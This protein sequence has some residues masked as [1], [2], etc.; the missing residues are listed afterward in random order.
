MEDGVA[1]RPVIR[2]RAPATSANL[3]PGFDCLA[4]ALDLENLI[5]V[6]PLAAGPL[7]IEVQGEGAEVLARDRSNLVVE[8]M[9]RLAAT[10]GRTLPP[11]ALRLCNAI[12]LG[13]GLGS[14]AAAIAGGLVVA[15]ALL[16][17]PTDLEILLPVALS[18]EEHPDNIAAALCGGFTVGVLDGER[19]IVY[20][21][22]PPQGLRAVLLVPD[23]FASTNESRAVL[24]TT[25]PRADAVYNS[26]RC[27]LLALALAEGRYDLLRVAMQDRLHQPQRG[28]GSFPYLGAAIAAALAA[29]AHGAA[30]SGAGSSVV[31]LATEN[32]EAIAAA[33]ARVAQ[34]YGLPARTMVLEPAVR[35][36]HRVKD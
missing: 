36:T 11:F 35:G 31:A 7:T 20:R 13:R 34:E 26:G 22:A 25:L 18:L 12:P 14:S 17:L 24:P 32:S 27:A 33:L 2:V 16:D 1:A 5:E 28:E 19:P 4:L 29:G 15:A 21:G 8:A 6:R 9:E 30:L 23:R 3:G 10:A